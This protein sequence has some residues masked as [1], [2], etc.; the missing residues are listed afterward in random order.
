[1]MT[2]SHKVKFDLSHGFPSHWGN[3][4]LEQEIKDTFLQ[5]EHFDLVINATWGMID[6]EHPL[7][8]AISNKFEITKDLVDNHGV[9]SILFFNFVD[10]MYD[11]STWY[12]VLTHCANKIGVDNIKTLGFIDTNK[13]KQDFSL[14][15]W[16]IF[17]GLEFQRYNDSDLYPEEFKNVFLCYNRKPTSHRKWLFEQF[18][19]HKLLSR[20]IF[21]LGNENPEKV[22]ICRN[23]T[24]T[25]PFVNDD[26]HGNYNIPNDTHSLG[27][28]EDWRQS[29][30]IIVTETDHNRH[31]A[32]PF[33]SEKIWKPL[34]GMRPFLVL[35]DKGTVRTLKQAGFETFNEFFGIKH[36]DA[37][38]DD[39]VKAVKSYNGDM[40]TDYETLKSKLIHN[41]KR[42]FEFVDEQK[43][44]I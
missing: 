35:G 38:V 27:P 8:S 23:D 5:R 18:E 20:G 33:L 22:M 10:P 28:I 11:A 43:N 21:T 31:T 37:A 30:L 15:F 25:S 26:I 44:L 16:A 39:I 29:F 13:F 12:H 3:G 9:K 19:K 24:K 40:A 34:I 17:T 6:C 42:Y 41:R 7:T 36:D 1:M 14:Q 32:V 4:Q 2:K